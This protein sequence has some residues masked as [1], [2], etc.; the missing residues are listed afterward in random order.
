MLVRV[1]VLLIVLSALAWLLIPAIPV[2]G[3]DGVQAAAVVGGLVLG[4]EV[5]FWLGLVLAGRDT[6][7]AVKEH[8]WRGVPKALWQ[9][10]RDGRPA[11][12]PAVSEE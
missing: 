5:A 3:L 2:L 10:L 7:R 1:G 4:A 6:W 8:G 9:M 12:R 11:S